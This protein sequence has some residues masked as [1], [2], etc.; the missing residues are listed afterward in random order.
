MFV[1]ITNQTESC[2]LPSGSQR[3]VRFT[4]FAFL[5]GDPELSGVLDA[6]GSNESFELV[7][8]EN[9]GDGSKKKGTEG[10]DKLK[11]IQPLIQHLVL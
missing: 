10:V 1:C 5:T 7:T 2:M 4:L 9:N 3:S 8:E 11:L 6:H